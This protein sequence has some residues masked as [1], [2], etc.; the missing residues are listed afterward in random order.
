ML[1]VYQNFM[2]NKQKKGPNTLT[3]YWEVDAQVSLLI[4]LRICFVFFPVVKHLMWFFW[5]FGV[6]D[7]KA[8]VCFECKT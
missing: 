7:N 6:L 8:N 4:V 1:T 3:L 2:M 5:K